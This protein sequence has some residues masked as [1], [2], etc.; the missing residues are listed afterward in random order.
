MNDSFYDTS[1]D[2]RPS[3]ATEKGTEVIV[4]VYERN[5]HGTSLT[6]QPSVVFHTDVI[7]R[8][9][10]NN[11]MQLRPIHMFPQL[12]HKLLP[13]ELFFMHGELVL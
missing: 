9:T 12:L 10:K 13:A 5:I 2:L 8:L 4:W 6:L 7:R 1:W 11:R 3:Y